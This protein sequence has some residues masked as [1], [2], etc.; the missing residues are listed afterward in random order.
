[1]A[2]IEQTFSEYKSIS[3]DK[4][5]GLTIE[6]CKKYKPILSSEV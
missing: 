1:M 3:V 4:Y 5:Q 2:F 6:F